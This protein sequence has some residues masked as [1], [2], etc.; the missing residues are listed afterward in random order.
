MLLLAVTLA[1]A[2]ASARAQDNGFYLGAGVSQAQIDD[3]G[4]DLGLGG[5]DLD[6]TT[7]KVIAGF[8]PLDRFAVEANYMDLGSESETFAGGDFDADA[9][10]VSGYLVGYLPFPFLDLYGKLGLAWWEAE[11]RASS[12]FGSF[13][14]DD[15]GTEFAWGLGVQARLGSLAARLEYEQFD[16]DN[17]D[18]LELVTLGATWTF[19]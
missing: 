15:D 13:D 12:T 1:L 11:A 18:G 14:L 7:W 4:D 3:I 2:A 9:R 8:R 16:I 5:F 19:L 6:D 17:T 10:A